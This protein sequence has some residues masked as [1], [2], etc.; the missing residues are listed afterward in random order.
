MAEY[1]WGFLQL[2]KVKE[3]SDDSIPHMNTHLERV[4]E[5]A[6][7]YEWSDLQKWSEEVCTRVSKGTLRWADTYI[8]D[9]LQTQLSHKNVLVQAQSSGGATS[10]R[11]DSYEMSDLVSQAKPGPPCKC[12]QAGTCTH[13]N[14]H[15]QKGYRQLHVC[16]YCL[17]NKCL[18]QP[19]STKECKTKKFNSQ[20][21]AQLELGFGN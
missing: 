4:L 8:I 19:H 14:D 21:K 6:M 5:G 11:M 18:L 13:T 10:P 9:R 7:M 2:I 17:A 3:F 20:K 15:V 1:T 16:S 12:F